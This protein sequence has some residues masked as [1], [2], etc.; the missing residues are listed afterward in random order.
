MVC[1]LFGAMPLSKPVTVNWTL[2]NKLQWNCNQNT[3]LIDENAFQMVVCEMAAV[4]SRRNELKW[5]IEHS[6]A[7]DKIFRKHK[8]PVVILLCAG[9]LQLPEPNHCLATIVNADV[10]PFFL[11]RI[12]H[13]KGYAYLGR[14]S[15]WYILVLA[16]EFGVVSYLPSIAIHLFENLHCLDFCSKNTLTG[17]WTTKKYQ[18]RIYVS[19]P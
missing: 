15:R 14:R 10:F 16:T 17:A 7:A 8:A 4:L 13:V 5:H 18:V 12:E 9:E 2:R 3:C 6:G 1:C 11:K 19:E